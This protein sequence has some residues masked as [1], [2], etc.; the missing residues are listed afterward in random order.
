MRH[1]RGQ[2]RPGP[3]ELRHRRRHHL[4]ARRRGRKD[5]IVRCN[6]D[7]TI[8]LE[9]CDIEICLSSGIFRDPIARRNHFQETCTNL[10]GGHLDSLNNEDLRSTKA[11]SVNDTQQI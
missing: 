4:C 10:V 3:D 6:N 7:I 2:L 11:N 1:V 5:W 8:Y 9:V